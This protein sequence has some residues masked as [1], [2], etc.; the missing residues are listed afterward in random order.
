M[1]FALVFHPAVEGEV[2]DAY[3][4]YEQQRAGL[5]DE[6]LQALEAVYSRLQATPQ[7][8]QQ[9]RGDV[10]RALLRRFPYSVYYRVHSDKVEIVAVQHQRRDPKAWQSRS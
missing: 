3:Q 7:I 9:I 5:G 1:S 8:H 2:E 10:R 4:W 6:F